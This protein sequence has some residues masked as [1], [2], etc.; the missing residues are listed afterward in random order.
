MHSSYITSAKLSWPRKLLAIVETPWPRKLRGLYI[1]MSS[2]DKK[3]NFN[4]EVAW[5]NVR[6]LFKQYFHAQVQKNRHHVVSKQTDKKDFDKAVQ[7]LK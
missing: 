4:D 6:T 2:D 1:E 3:R 7:E 5:D